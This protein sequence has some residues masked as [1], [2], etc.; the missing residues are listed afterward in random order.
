MRSLEASKLDVQISLWDDERRRL[1]G[2]APARAGAGA[3]AP[4]PDPQELCCL[5][6]DGLRASA[7]LA[8]AEPDGTPDGLP[9]E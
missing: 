9:L 8:D 4:E 1:A 5:A 3:R 7:E 2:P 6:L